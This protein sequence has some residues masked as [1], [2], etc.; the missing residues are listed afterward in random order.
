M[1]KYVITQVVPSE[2]LFAHYW[3]INIETLGEF[4]AYPNRDSLPYIDKYGIQTADSMYRGTLRNLGWCDTMKK[5][6]D[7]GFL[8]ETERPELKGKTFQA[9]MGGMIDAGEGDELKSALATHLGLDTE[10]EPLKR[11]E[12]LGLLSDDP[13]PAEPPNYLDVLANKLLEKLQYTPGERDMVVL[14]HEFGAVYTDDNR[15]EKL[16]STLID[17]GIPNGDTSMARTVGLPC[18]IGVKMVA[19]GKIT[20]KGVHIPILADI[21]EPILNELEAKGIVFQEKIVSE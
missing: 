13:V 12:W 1:K 18:A 5:I 11:F 14:H 7:L 16:T 21:Y 10:S 4:E 2:E 3:K 20:V 6:V 15:E 19:D 8:D 17:F 9:L